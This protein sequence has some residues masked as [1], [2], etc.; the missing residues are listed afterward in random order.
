MDLNTW[1]KQ[2]KNKIKATRKGVQHMK[3]FKLTNSEFKGSGNNLYAVSVLDLSVDP[4]PEME[5][6]LALD[7]ENLLSEVMED[8]CIE[9]EQLDCKEAEINCI[10]IGSFQNK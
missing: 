10:L 8:A 3:T 9:Q 2:E 5:L 7:E 4:N 1:E 6:W